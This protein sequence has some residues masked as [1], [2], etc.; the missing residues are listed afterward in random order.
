MASIKKNLI[1]VFAYRSTTNSIMPDQMALSAPAISYSS[2]HTKYSLRP[3]ETRK[4]F[5]DPATPGPERDFRRLF[6][7]RFI[8]GRIHIYN[9]QSVAACYVTQIF[10]V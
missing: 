10:P 8:S 5:A 2:A 1:P 9:N 7:G 6:A 3:P 4:L